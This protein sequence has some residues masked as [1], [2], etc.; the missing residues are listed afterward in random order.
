MVKEGEG[1]WCS[2][3]KRCVI[4]FEGGSGE[5][6]KEWE[7]REGGGERKRGREGERGREGGKGVRERVEGWL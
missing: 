5:I 6:R 2:N 7:E 1:A 3:T 4:F